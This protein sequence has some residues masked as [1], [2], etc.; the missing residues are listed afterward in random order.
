MNNET[1]GGENRTQE[2]W[3]SSVA[4]I[5]GTWHLAI[6][7][8]QSATWAAFVYWNASGESVAWADAVQTAGEKSW[9]AIPAF[10]IINEQTCRNGVSYQIM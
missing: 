8:M 1:N 6:T 2:S 9:P 3:L 10:F 5:Y 7:A 4:R